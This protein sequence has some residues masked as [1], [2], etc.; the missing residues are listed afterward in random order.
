[1]D[2]S[3]KI[4]N[5]VTIGDVKY[6]DISGPSGVPDGIISPEYDRVLLG[7][8]LPRYL[9]GGNI[10]L[11]YKNFDFL[12]AFQG[13]GKKLSVSQ[14]LGLNTSWNYYTYFDGNYWSSYNTDEQN[15]KVKYPRLTYPTT[16]ETKDYIMSDFWLVNGAYF[17]IKNITLGYNIPNTLSEK[18]KI[19]NLRIYASISDLYSFNHYPKGLDPETV[20]TGYWTTTS[21]LFGIS[22]KF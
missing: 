16:S 12:I 4:N 18:L 13:I 21:Y 15:Q 3:A 11:G 2:N 6:K 20:Y 5:S 19:K 10:S 7:G 17:R 9:Y 14:E 22:A 1:V 8:S